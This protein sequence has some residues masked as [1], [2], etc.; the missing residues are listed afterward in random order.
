[1][2]LSKRGPARGETPT[3]LMKGPPELSQNKSSYASPAPNF[4][5]CPGPPPQPP[6]PPNLNA[7]A[8]QAATTQQPTHSKVSVLLPH[9]ATLGSVSKA[10]A[11]T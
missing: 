10:E 4:P 5:N 2:E 3:Q 11:P 8:E 6:R 9:I 7:A 1:M